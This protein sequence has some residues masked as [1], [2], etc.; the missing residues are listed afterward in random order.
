MISLCLK[1]T[2]SFSANKWQLLERSKLEMLAQQ[3]KTNTA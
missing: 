1:V 3:E 2:K